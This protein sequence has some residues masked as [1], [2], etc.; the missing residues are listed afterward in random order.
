MTLRRLA[1]SSTFLFWESAPKRR[2][3][4]DFNARHGLVAGV[5]VAIVQFAA[6]F[7]Y[8][9][10]AQSDF[11]IFQ[12]TTQRFVDGLRMYSA[13]SVDFTPPLF[14]ALLLPLAHVP[15][16]LA[17]VL[18][19]ALS[20]TVAWLVF[21]MTV[22][23]VPGAWTR[24]W[25]IAAWVANLAGV[26]MTLRLGQV[27][28]LVALLVT[29]A[30]LAARNGRWTAMGVWAGV[31]IAFKPFLL[32]ILPVLAVRRQWKGLAVSVATIAVCCALSAMCFGRAAFADWLSNLR[33]TP[34]QEYATHF[35]NASWFAF[36]ARAHAPYAVATALSGLTILLMLWRARTWDEDVTWLVVGMVALLACPIGWVYYQPMLLGPVIALAVSGRIPHLRW[37]AATCFVPALSSTLF[38]GSRVVAL[39]LG[40]VYFWGFL[41]AFIGLVFWPPQL[42]RMRRC[43]G[44]PSTV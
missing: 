27:S 16:P 9:I 1:L 25:T 39:T 38:Q 7:V 32:L 35:L 10:E 41:V 24:R 8:G 13:D 36:I 17:F 15:P 6:A 2:R 33:A 29:R 4:S 14:H 26:H 30:W 37:A 3:F 5:V 21:M 34:A 40:S 20:V 23:A 22:R 18:W 19:T 28:W 11:G 43:A 31:A 44:S 42:V 12:K